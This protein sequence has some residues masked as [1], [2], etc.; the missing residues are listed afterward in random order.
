VRDTAGVPA[1]TDDPLGLMGLTDFDADP[2]ADF[3][4]GLGELFRAPARFPFPPLADVLLA[5]L[6]A[7]TLRPRRPSR[8]YGPSSNTPMARWRAL[9]EAS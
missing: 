2:D 8:V 6:P 1:R 5:D 3:R 7:V 9:N 4:A